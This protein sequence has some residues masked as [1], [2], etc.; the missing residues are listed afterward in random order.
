MENTRKYRILIA[1]LC[2]V[3]LGV[4]LWQLTDGCL[5][6]DEIFGVHAAE[7][8]WSGMWWFVAQD[9]VHPPL[10][11]GLLKIW[12]GIGGDGLLWLRMFPVLFSALALFPFLHLC[13]EMKLGDTTIVLALALFAVNGSLVKYSQT[14]RMY[15][16]LMFLS[17]M[18]VWLFARYFNRGKSWIWL[19]VVNILLVYT[20]YFGWLVVGAEFLAIL[21]FQRMKIVRAAL[22]ASIAAAA[23]VPWL[24]AILN[25]ER[26]SADLEQNIS[27]QTRPGIGE[28]TKFLL[29]LVEP[30]Y[31]P[32]SSLE[33]PSVLFVAVPLLLLF[34]IV[35]CVFVA[36]K[37]SD[38]EKA[39]VRFAV[40]FTAFPL[41]AAFAL[42]WIL[43]NSVWGTR[44][45]ILA[46]PLFVILAG[47]SIS[48]LADKRIRIGAICLIAALV[49]VAFVL[50]IG[51]SEQ[52][53]V[54]CAWEGVAS[55]I[56]IAESSND[57][58]PNVYAFEDLAAYHLWFAGRKQ[59]RH[60]VSVA[61]GVH[62]Q[63]DDR[64]FFL[65]RGFSA[66]DTSNVDE[67]KDPEL[68]LAFRVFQIG[69]E[70][71]LIEVLTSRGYFVCSSK[72]QA[73][74]T[75]RVFWMKF[76]R[77]SARCSSY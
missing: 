9:L 28:V 48:Y 14:L 27:W 68:W 55:E 39:F 72:Q 57:Q 36:G 17:L 13:R 73:Y 56:R 8:S 52:K 54:W 2:A 59:G 37:K 7:H 49:S 71:P 38:E 43:P 63:T 21:I 22:M 18:S 70:F 19:V 4:R 66:V 35:I 11:Y 20:H 62:V 53:Q 25:R 58:P 76:A 29:T 45:L 1:A 60:Q 46:T 26:L 30:F 61:K 40:L 32:A 51:R 44:H 33:Q 34:A 50:E 42:S 10:F 74:G 3:Y 75:N 15:S 12:I 77:D 6:F 65:P 5:W 31:T 41:L 47:A 67:I 24:I 16:L 64:S 23:F 69:E